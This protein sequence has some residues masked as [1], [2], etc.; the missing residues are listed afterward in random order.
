MK[1]LCNLMILHLINTSSW[2]LL[3]ASSELGNG[4]TKIHHLPFTQGVHNYVEI[5]TLK[6]F[7]VPNLRDR[8][9][10]GFIPTVNTEMEWDS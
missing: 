5:K 6:I 4:D 3:R 1:S 2:H 9:V 10:M 7:P 8:F